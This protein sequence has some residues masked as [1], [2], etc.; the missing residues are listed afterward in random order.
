[1]MVAAHHH[2]WV[3][4][5]C[6][7]CGGSGERLPSLV[8]GGGGEL[9]LPSLIVGSWSHRRRGTPGWTVGVPHCG[10]DVGMDNLISYD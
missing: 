1:M 8:E 3:V 6:G 2:S 10:G 4:G 7:C 5:T 9:L